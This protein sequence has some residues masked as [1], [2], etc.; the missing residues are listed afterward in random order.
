M[1]YSFAAKRSFLFCGLILCLL[2]NFSALNLAAQEAESARIYYAEGTD[3]TVTLNGDRSDISADTVRGAGVNIVPSGIVHTGSGAFLE[4]QLLPSGTVVKLSENTSFIYNGIDET[5]KF[6]D[7]GLLYGRMRIVTG[8]RQNS[9]GTNSVVI[10]GG[11]VSARIE[12]GD[13]GVDYILEPGGQ[14]FTAR[15]IFRIYAFRGGT[16]VFP[17]R[18]MGIIAN[19]GGAQSLTAGDG[20][21][22]SLDVSSSYTFAERK[23]MDRDILAYWRLHNFTGPSPLPMPNTE[24]VLAEPAAPQ[25][26]AGT[27]A[28]QPPVITAS[29]YVPPPTIV[30]QQVPSRTLNRK[31]NVC[32]IIG[33]S[34]TASSL[35]AQ[36]VTNFVFDIENDPIPRNIYMGAYGTLGLGLVSTLVGII[37]NPK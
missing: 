24:I 35:A 22:L 5:G 13:F 8:T 1:A 12:D 18:N 31:K 14:N 19:F 6:S 29:A 34:L 23:P 7:L 4:I 21:I 3:I 15:P 25:P 26:A 30:Y 2:L 9:A 28:S 36:A 16:E 33:L 37:F 17:Y 32:L 11:G 20:E 27:E 10:R